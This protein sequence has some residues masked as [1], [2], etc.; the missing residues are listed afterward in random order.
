VLCRECTAKQV[1][2]QRTVRAKRRS[3]G[4]CVTC[5]CTSSTPTCDACREKRK[6]RYEALS[7]SGRCPECAEEVAPGKHRCP[8]CL[9]NARLSARDRREARRARLGIP[10]P[11]RTCSRCGELGHYRPGCKSTINLDEVAA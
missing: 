11:A 5:G 6:A 7:A 2:Y 4:L 3:L 9:E 8:D 10:A 1:E